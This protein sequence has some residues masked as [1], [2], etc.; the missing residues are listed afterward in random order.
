MSL[1]RGSSAYKTCMFTP[2]LVSNKEQGLYRSPTVTPFPVGKFPPF[3]YHCNI[4]SWPAFLLREYF[5]SSDYI[6]YMFWQNA[7]EKT[8]SYTYTTIAKNSSLLWVFR[9]PAGGMPHNTVHDCWKS[10]CFTVWVGQVQLGRP[11]IVLS[12]STTHSDHYRITLPCP[13]LA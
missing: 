12:V 2:V 5:P 4:C 3:G 8:Y 1:S 6:L 9:I 7:P 11:Y 10:L 13:V